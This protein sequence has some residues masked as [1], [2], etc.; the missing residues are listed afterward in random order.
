MVPP[1]IGAPALAAAPA[2]R[3]SLAVRL[4]ELHRVLT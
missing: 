3:Q 2:S 4:G 1:A